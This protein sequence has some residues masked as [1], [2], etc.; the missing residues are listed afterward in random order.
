MKDKFFE[1]ILKAIFENLGPQDK[2]EVME[3]LV[4]SIK[5]DMKS[6]SKLP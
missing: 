1:P 5:K 4:K 6:T 2:I 3:I